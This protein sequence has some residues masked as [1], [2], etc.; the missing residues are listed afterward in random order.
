MF[1]NRA[2]RKTIPDISVKNWSKLK[3]YKLAWK[4]P[5]PPI[6]RPVEFLYQLYTVPCKKLFSVIHR[7][8]HLWNSAGRYFYH[9]QGLNDPLNM[10]IYKTS[11]EHKHVIPNNT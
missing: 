5:P 4:H 10:L 2:I 1:R 3:F 8:I 7:D 6:F 11:L 9:W